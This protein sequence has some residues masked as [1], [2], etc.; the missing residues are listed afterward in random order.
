[1]HKLHTL[2]DVLQFWAGTDPHRPYLFTSTEHL[3]YVQVQDTAVKLTDL[4]LRT[5]ALPKRP[6]L[7]VCVLKVEH[8][9]YLIWACLR[10]GICLAFLPQTLDR[11][12]IEASMETVGAT[13]LMTDVPA[14]MEFTFAVSIEN[15]LGQVTENNLSIPAASLSPE[16]PAFILH[17]SGTM[18]DPKWVQISQGQFLRAIQALYQMGGLNHAQNQFVYLTPPLSHSYG[19]SAF[20][21]YTFVGS[22]ITFASSIHALSLM[23]ELA[24]KTLANQ[25]TAIEGVPDFYRL[26]TKF[27]QKISLPQLRHIGW[28][29]GAVDKDV[30]AKWTERYSTLNRSISCSVRYGLTETPSVVSHHVVN[31][32]TV[33]GDFMTGQVLPLYDVLVMDESG[34]PIGPHQVGEILL[35]GD[36]LAMPYLGDP[37]PQNEYF[38]TGDLGYLDDHGNLSVTGRKSLFIKHKGFRI[39]PEYIESV[40]LK[41]EGILDCRVSLQAEKLVAEVVYPV[42]NPSAQTILDFLKLR[43]PPYMMPQSILFTGNVPRTASGK[44]KR[45]QNS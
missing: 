25:I 43:L 5:L 11:A 7:A 20:L 15:L 32:L 10:S 30:L 9:V 44:L 17:T 37:T 19:L 36:C 41:L 21:E 6:V 8:L 38:A 26:L 2:S 29:G 39:S 18:G 40:L 31:L 28:G 4:L 3:S 33:A 35:K 27:Q 22:A 16:V 13:T 23:G 12:S 24:N 1:M 45:H 34:H 14:L 42:S